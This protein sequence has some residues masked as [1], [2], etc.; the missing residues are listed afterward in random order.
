MIWHS[1][2]ISYQAHIKH[3]SSTYQDICFV[4]SDFRL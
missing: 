4:W 3:I 2:Y 1:D